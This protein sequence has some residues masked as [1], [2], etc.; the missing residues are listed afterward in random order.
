MNPYLLDDINNYIGEEFE[1]ILEDSFLYPQPEEVKIPI[2][3]PIV[4]YESIKDNSN[5]KE[6]SICLSEI[7]DKIHISITK[8]SHLFHNKCIS[9]WSIHKTDCPICRTD[10]R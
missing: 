6:C 1:R 5:D 9:E 8:C 10:M 2:E 7:D 4:T 3:F